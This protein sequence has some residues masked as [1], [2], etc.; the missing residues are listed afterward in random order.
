MS[1][2]I[3]I[4]CENLGKTTSNVIVRSNII[5]NNDDAGIVMGGFNFP[6]GSGK[7]IDCHILNNTTYNNDILSTGIG[8][9]TGEV[10]ISYTEN[11]TLQNRVHSGN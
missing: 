8:G 9:L 4:G 10:N 7:V 5:Y 11:C 2:G 3:E 1:M 6:T